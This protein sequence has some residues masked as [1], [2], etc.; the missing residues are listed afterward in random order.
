M[1]V[2]ESFMEISARN[3][4]FNMHSIARKM[5]AEAVYKALLKNML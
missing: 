4:L 3:G 5:C 1:R 2:L